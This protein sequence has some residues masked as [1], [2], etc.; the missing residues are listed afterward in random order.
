MIRATRKV[1]LRKEL[2]RISLNIYFVLIIIF[3]ITDI[4]CFIIELSAKLYR[5]VISKLPSYWATSN[6]LFISLGIR[7]KAETHVCFLINSIISVYISTKNEQ[8]Y[9]SSFFQV[10]IILVTACFFY[11]GFI[12]RPFTNHKAEW[13]EKGVSLIPDYHFHPHHIHLEISRAIIAEN[14]PLHIAS[15]LIRNGN[16]WFP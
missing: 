6:K 9:W 5:R 14:L 3:V 12:S 10:S 11:L 15:S 4:N 2:K 16:L 1:L 13:N 8:V 7:F